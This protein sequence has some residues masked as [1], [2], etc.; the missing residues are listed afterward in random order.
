MKRLFQFFRFIDTL[1]QKRTGLDA[2]GSE[3]CKQAFTK[4]ERVHFTFQLDER[5]WNERKSC[6]AKTSENFGASSEQFQTSEKL[7]SSLWLV[8]MGFIEESHFSDTVS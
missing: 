5:G 1:E 8:E 4:R 7:F 3:L 6:D 2:M